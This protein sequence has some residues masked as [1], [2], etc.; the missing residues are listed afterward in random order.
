MSSNLLRFLIS[1]LF[2]LCAL[3]E[4]AGKDFNWQKSALWVAIGVLFFV[5]LPK[6]DSA[7]R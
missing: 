6:S 7:R 1:G 3:V 5:S 2:L 4:Y